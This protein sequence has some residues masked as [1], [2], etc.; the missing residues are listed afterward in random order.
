MTG[1]EVRSTP[2][3]A[4][5]TLELAMIYIHPRSRRE[6]R[7]MV[8][9]H[10]FIHGKTTPRVLVH[11][12]KSARQ[13]FDY[14]RKNVIRFAPPATPDWRNATNEIF[15][16]FARETKATCGFLVTS[17][18]A[19][20][21]VYPLVPYR[22]VWRA[23][24]MDDEDIMHGELAELER[25]CRDKSRA[26]AR[27]R[28]RKSPERRQQRGVFE[29]P[30][31]RASAPLPKDAPAAA[32]ELFG[33]VGE[34]SVQIANRFPSLRRIYMFEWRGRIVCDAARRHPR[35]TVV[36][37]DIRTMNYVFVPPGA[38]V[39]ASP[40]CEGYSPQRRS[41]FAKK[42]TEFA[43]SVLE[44][45]DTYVR[46][47]L[48]FIRAAAALCWVLENPSAEL[49]NRLAIWKHV[50]YDRFT[51]TYCK[52]GFD[53]RK[54]TDLFVSRELGAILRVNGGG[55]KAPCSPKAS[56]CD[57]IKCG[58]NHPRVAAGLPAWML[59]RVPKSLVNDILDRGVA[60]Y[61]AATY[62]DGDGFAWRRSRGR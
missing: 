46:V 16:A 35:V 9:L 4:E 50:H 3:E 36:V 56:P 51:V 21:C 2:H 22:L 62:G 8:K 39:W 34:I 55:F 23:D 19:S 49:R 61:L 42:G 47:T 54:R 6:V 40:P 59:G 43:K 37:T 25:R 52:Y 30:S 41:E 44:L 60:P 15:F 12:T 28:A 31:T 11:E 13:R 27:D 18:D 32:Y 38:F 20:I 58:G 17:Y 33:G 29:V 14:A 7:C 57:L 24:P 45:A 10:D 5:T 53:Y 26:R 48:D 1:V